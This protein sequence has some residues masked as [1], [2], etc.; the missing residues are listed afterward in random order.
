MVAVQGQAAA[1][2]LGPAS[3][4]RDGK[5]K[6]KRK[7]DAFSHR[8]FFVV[9][10][11]DRAGRLLRLV[12][13]RG[14]VEADFVYLVRSRARVETNVPGCDYC[15]TGSQGELCFGCCSFGV[16]HGC[17]VDDFVMLRLDRPG[18]NLYELSHMFVPLREALAVP[19]G[20][21][22][23]ESCVLAIVAFGP[24]PDGSVLLAD[25]SYVLVRARIN[26]MC[27]QGTM[28]ALMNYRVLDGVLVA[29]QRGT[30]T[31]FSKGDPGHG[32]SLRKWWQRF[33]Q[34]WSA[35][36]DQRQKQEQQLQQRQ[37]QQQQKQE[38][39]FIPRDGSGQSRSK[40]VEFNPRDTSGRSSSSSSKSV[41][42]AKKRHLEEDVPNSQDIDFVASD[43]EFEPG[44][45][46]DRVAKLLPKPLDKYEESHLPE[47]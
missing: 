5:N 13:L 8:R 27:S 36:E 14:P 19:Q 1:L 11:V 31:V 39:E 16:D 42:A 25:S 45:E 38:G 10:Q 30:V 34:V 33:G 7:N 6:K 35:K 32:S 41:P 47:W 23:P 46:D 26:A 22:Q 9:G 4:S 2:R 29:G 40:S 3:V 43:H 18:P 37:Q 12:G 44:E 21:V 17:A 28:V 20:H 24:F 15:A